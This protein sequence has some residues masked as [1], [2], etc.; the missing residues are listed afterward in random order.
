MIGAASEHGRPIAADDVDATCSGSCRVNDWSAR[1][2][3]AY[4]YQ[5]L[6]PF[7]GKSFAT[8]MSPWIVTL[9]ALD[10][11]ASSRRNKTPNPT[12]TFGRHCRGA[13]TSTSS[14]SSTAR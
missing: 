6:G 13:S 3:Q 7:L 5:P 4:E 2:I 1:D 12:P 10:P 8:S 14:S 9:D 11:T